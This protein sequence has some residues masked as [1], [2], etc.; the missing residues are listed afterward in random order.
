MTGFIRGWL[1]P[2]FPDLTLDDLAGILDWPCLPTV[3]HETRGA[4][5]MGIQ[6]MSL[7][8]MVFFGLVMLGT[9]MLQM[10]LRVS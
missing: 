8:R 4:V 7:V 2:D 5:A 10:E 6:S 3:V 9:G 1:M